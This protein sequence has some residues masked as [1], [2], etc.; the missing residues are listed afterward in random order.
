MARLLAQGESGQ[1][2][3]VSG[4]ESTPRGWPASTPGQQGWGPLDLGSEAR[5]LKSDGAG[6]EGEVSPGR[7][8][9]QRKACG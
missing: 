7:G 4:K 5:V 3:V 9:A 2:R 8:P 6:A 1:D